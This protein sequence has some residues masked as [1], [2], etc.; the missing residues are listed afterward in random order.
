MHASA[1]RTH[2]L[3]IQWE[4]RAQLP[5]LQDLAQDQAVEAQLARRPTRTRTWASRD[6]AMEEEVKVAVGKAGRCSRWKILAW[7]WVNMVSTSREANSTDD[8]EAVGVMNQTS[9]CTSSSRLFCSRRACPNAATWMSAAAME[10]ATNAQEEIGMCNRPPG[11]IVSH[12]IDALNSLDLL[13]SWSHQER[14]SRM[15]PPWQTD[16]Y[17]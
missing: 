15:E 1:H 13:A 8:E 10:E 17:K 12:R 3:P 5:S 14:C 7:P 16:L 4:P 9:R 2:H 11:L 6:L